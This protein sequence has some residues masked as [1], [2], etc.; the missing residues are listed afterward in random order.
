MKL[1]HLLPI[2]TIFFLAACTNGA[3]TGPTPVVSTASTIGYPGANTATPVSSVANAYPVQAIVIPT[4]VHSTPDPKKAQ[5]HGFIQLN[6]IPFPGADLYLAPII[7]N[8]QSTE[9]AAQL[10]REDDPKTTTDTNGEYLFVNVS[11]GQYVLMYYNHPQ[12]YL[13]LDPKTHLAE[14]VKIEVGKNIDLG[15]LSYDKLPE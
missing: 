3:V 12:A 15:I 2:F 6:G 1:S 9:V 13:L 8:A 7:V 5:V 4:L 14:K 11:P 10:N